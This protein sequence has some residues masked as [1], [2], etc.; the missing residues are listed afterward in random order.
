MKQK[1]AHILLALVALLISSLACQFLGGQTGGDSSTEVPNATDTPVV[2]PTAS[3]PSPVIKEGQPY[4]VRGSFKVTNDFVLKNYF[5]EHAVAVLDMHGFVIRD[6]EW[7]L[8]VESQVL[9]DMDVQSDY[10]GGTFTVLL[11]LRP[12]GEYNDVDNNGK[13]D[14]GVQIFAVGYA[15]NL[16]GEPFAEDDDRSRGW[17]SYLATVKADPENKDEIIGGQMLVW[18]P[19]ESQ[20][21][22][23]D[24]GPDG[25]LF[26]A[27]DPVGPIPAGYSVV[28][29]DVRPFGV[30]Q[31]PE[32]QLTLY[33]PAD[34]AKK[35]FSDLGMLEAFEKMFEIVRKEYAFTGIEGKSPDWDALYAE[36]KPKVEKAQQ[37]N[38]ERAFYEAMRILYNAFQDGHVSLGGDPMIQDFWATNGG[39]FG[40]TIREL[41][42]KRVIVD[43]VKPDGQADKLGIK[44]GAEV[45][46]YNDKPIS[47]AIDAVEPFFQESSPASI[48]YAQAVWLVRASPG[49]QASVTF[50]NPG[51]A[52]K[53][54]RLTAEQETEGLFTQLGWNESQAILPVES[55]VIERDGKKIGHIRLLSNADDLNLTIRLF[56]RA[57]KTFQEREVAGLIID[58]RN[59][60]G[61]T[62]LGL[63]GFLTE[64]ELIQGQL[65]YFSEKTGQFEPEGDPGKIIANT[66]QYRFDKL[67]LLVGRG[68]YSACELESDGF[69]KVP[70]MVVI[71]ETPSAGVEAETA[72]GNFTLPGGIEFTVPTGRFTNPDG[73]LFLEGQGVVPSILV[74]VTEESVLGQLDA[75]LEAAIKAVLGQ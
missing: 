23:T 9:G 49:D 5:Y 57:L 71:G 66:N 15:P 54:V 10:L 13:T 16:Y 20:Q 3:G 55:Q 36:L 35:D 60:S 2:F 63:A 73:S 53:T 22:P 21:F 50:K 51:G 14:T 52:S 61:G 19:D 65:S 56:E 37:G 8:P 68:C 64:N 1:N 17:P 27:D 44:Q 39:G 69:S 28:D 67:V 26:T 75:V 7:E 11:P 58:M 62:N 72:R 33:E 31:T 6:D 74:P 41:T 18:S 42:D 43:W 70:G 38:N 24:F 30:T 59:N 47:E 34:I 25:L 46:A 45:T 48:R 32:P 29:L 4:L 40:F 12:V